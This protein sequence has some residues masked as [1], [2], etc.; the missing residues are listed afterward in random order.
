MASI[1]ASAGPSATGARE[2]P[3]PPVSLAEVPGWPAELAAAAP[4]LGWPLESILS[5]C[6]TQMNRPPFGPT[7]VFGAVITE[8]GVQFRGARPSLMRPRPTER[9]WCTYS[10]TYRQTSLAPADVSDVGP[11]RPPFV[12]LRRE[13]LPAGTN[14]IATLGQVGL[15]GLVIAWSE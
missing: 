9:I 7:Y 5:D 11:G 15:G 8:D 14:R 2:G 13:H 1:V 3:L 6:L 12:A 4:R 10:A